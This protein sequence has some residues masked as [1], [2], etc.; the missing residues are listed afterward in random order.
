[1]TL[2]ITEEFDKN[3]F[4]PWGGATPVWE[5]IYNAGKADEF[6]SLVEEQYPDGIDRTSL[7][8]ILAFDSDWVLNSLGIEEEE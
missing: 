5:R 6:E 3:T 8:D 2:I 1:M 4:D 7:N